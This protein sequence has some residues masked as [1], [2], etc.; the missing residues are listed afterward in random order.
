M[1]SYHNPRIDHPGHIA[2]A[3]DG[4]V[5]ISFSKSLWALSMLLGSVFGLT[6]FFSWSG[7]VLYVVS[8][9]LVLCLGHSL[10]MHRLFIHRAY[11]VPRWLSLLLIHLG[12]VTGIAGPMNMLYTHDLRDWA[13][14][15][16]HC[17][18][19]FAQSGVWY[20]DLWWQVCCNI[21]LT[22]PPFFKPEPAIAQ[23]RAVQWMERTWMLQQLPWAVLFFYFG[24]WSWVCWGIC[25]RVSSCIF[26][27]WLI[28]YFAHNDELSKH[29]H[30]SWHVEQAAVQGQNVRWTSLLAMGENWHNNHHAFPYSA[31][32]GLES[33]QWDPGWWIL[34]G[35]ARLGIAT[36]LVLPEPATQRCDL[37]RVSANERT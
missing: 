8:T 1:H 7:L 26:G 19:M 21:Q 35:L 30:R 2:D 12:T 33:G 22:R 27:H 34:S 16:A 23:D 13:Q 29:M 31:R 36:H 24:G 4:H 37:T 6:V 32:M 10:G 17:H 18:A 28:G 20:R 9:W 11:R 5:T 15:Q 25:A 14:R 3:S